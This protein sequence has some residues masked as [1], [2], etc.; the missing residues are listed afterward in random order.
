MRLLSCA[1]LLAVSGVVCGQSPQYRF[2]ITVLAGDAATPV[3]LNVAVPPLTSHKLQ[4]TEHLS[5]ELQTPAAE[6]GNVVTLTKLIDDSSGS[7]VVI[8]VSQRGGP[9]ALERELAY[10]VCPAGR[11]IF[12]SPSLSNQASCAALPPMAPMEK[13]I[14]RCGDCA[15]P[16]EGMPSTFTSRARIAPEDEPGEPLVLTGQVRDASGKA[17]PNIIVYAYHT[18]RFGIYP[19][20][21]PLRSMDS[22]HQGRLRGWTVTD[23]KGRYTFDTIRPASYPKTTEPAHI[24]MHVIERGCGTYFVDE[25]VF[26]DDPFLTPEAIKRV[27]QGYGGTAI[28]SP[29]KQGNTWRITRD[30]VLGEKIPEYRACPASP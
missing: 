18:D 24:H 30:I 4:A 15:G 6:Q 9:V 28:V 14:G 25:V 7:P 27:S 17:R 20:P 23:A 1:L 10:R 22:N 3:H 13:V 12:E 26:K 5:V 19:N 11:V 16:F 21:N 8:A 2:S 29:R